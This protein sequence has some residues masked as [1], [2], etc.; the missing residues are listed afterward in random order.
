MSALSPF[1]D[2]ANLSSRERAH[3]WPQPPSLT[4]TPSDDDSDPSISAISKSEAEYVHDSSADLQRA[5][6]TGA[7]GPTPG[8]RG[9]HLAWTISPRLAQPPSIP[10]LSQY[11]LSLSS[12]SLP[13]C[14]RSKSASPT[15]SL[16]ASLFL[17]SSSFLDP[18]L[19]QQ[20][21]HVNSNSLLCAPTP[22]STTNYDPS[23]G[24]TSTKGNSNGIRNRANTIATTTSPPPTRRSALATT[25]AFFSS[26]SRPSWDPFPL[27]HTTSS[28]S[29]SH[30]G[31]HGH[32]NN[33][34]ASPSPNASIASSSSIFHPNPISSEDARLL[35]P[36]YL[37]SATLSFQ[38]GYH[39]GGSAAYSH[40]I[41][42]IDPQGTLHDPDYRPFPLIRH[43]KQ[44]IPSPFAI[45]KPYWETEDVDLEAEF[46]DSYGD[47][48]YDTDG[49]T[50]NTPTSTTPFICYFLETHPLKRGTP[51]RAGPSSQP[52]GSDMSGNG[53]RGRRR[54]GKGGHGHGGAGARPQ[55]KLGA[56]YMY[57]TFATGVGNRNPNYSHSPITPTTAPAPLPVTQYTTALSAS[58]PRMDDVSMGKEKR[59]WGGL[60]WKSGRKE[61]EKD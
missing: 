46:S 45:R 2:T 54:K 4:L 38:N 9:H 58:P 31:T 16:S 23:S 6:N 30:G 41:P 51:S 17:D 14:S 43:T 20:E 1:S 35:D 25:A 57:A 49:S 10:A 22:C 50:P 29:H 40:V 32:T 21:A 18:E 59:S 33:T 8:P 39:G 19:N 42:Y 52:F 44:P 34:I 28:H 55:L 5:S 11:S 36:S 53:R 3:T 61:G 7:D 48:G 15:S 56:T 13:R 26:M 47:D 37:S 60:L 12:L 24:N 27:I